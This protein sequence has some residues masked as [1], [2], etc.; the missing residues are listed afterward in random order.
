M[1][2]S[3][4]IAA[5]CAV[6]MACTANPSVAQQKLVLGSGFSS[7]EDQKLMFS[8]VGKVVNKQYAEAEELYN[9]AIAINGS[10]IEAYLQRGIVRREMGNARGA[11]ADGQQVVSMANALLQSNSQNVTALYQRGMGER[12]TRDFAAAKQDIRT[13]IQM[14][15]SAS[16]QTDLQAIDFEEKAARQ[17]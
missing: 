8:A 2:Y 4:W 1:K 3:Q 7:T 12:L 13:A 6:A 10:N 16:W 5:A 15:G 9:R 14:G 11:A 17:N